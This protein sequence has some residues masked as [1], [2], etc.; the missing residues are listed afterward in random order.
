M[1]TVY[2]WTRIFGGIQMNSK[3]VETL[4]FMCDKNDPQDKK[5][6]L[7]AELVE[8]KC[9]A[10]GENQKRLQ[11]SLD[12][13]NRKLDKLT[14]LLERYEND[15]HGCP[16]YRNKGDYERISFYVRNP[17]MT[18]LMILGLLAII[19]GFFGSTITNLVKGL[20]GL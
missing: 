20:F 3:I 9:N 7:L 4:E 12:Y 16:V 6:L 2:G 5:M 19:G 10:L 1:T 11:E 13:T 18:L 17:K 15:T 8:N 14:E